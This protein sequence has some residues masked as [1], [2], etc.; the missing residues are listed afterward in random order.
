L[1]LT[2]FLRSACGEP[3]RR[4]LF[5]LFGELSAHPLFGFELQT[6]FNRASEEVTRGGPIRV[7]LDL[8]ELPSRVGDVEEF[9]DFAE[10]RV[11]GRVDAEAVSAVA[12]YCDC[13][14]DFVSRM[15]ATGFELHINL[16]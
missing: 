7:T 8:F 5:F 2:S 15:I 16:R 4:R 3:D 14:F 9:A 1:I 11:V 10:H 13:R 6:A 12:K